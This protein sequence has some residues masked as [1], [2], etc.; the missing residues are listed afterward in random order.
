MDDPRPNPPR[1]SLFAVWRWQRRT[2]VMFAPLVLP[3]YVLSVGPADR[4][5]HDGFLAGPL[6]DFVMLIYWPLATAC[7][8][9][10]SFNSA[11]EWYLRWWGTL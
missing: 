2:W 5:R 10:P 4:L 3:S 6:L 11:M 1:R 8:L 7:Q 9:S